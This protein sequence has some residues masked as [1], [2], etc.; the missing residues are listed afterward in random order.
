[1]CAVGYREEEYAMFGQ[2]MKGRG[3][4]MEQCLE[5]F[6][7]A[8]TGEPFDYEGRLVQVTPKPMTPGGPTLLMGGSSKIAVRRAARFGMG[9]ITQG[10]DSSLQELYEETCREA[11]T[12]PGMFVNPSVGD[13]V[14][15]GF[16]ARDPDQA[17]AE[18]GSFLLHDAQMYAAWLG[19]AATATRSAAS[20]VEELRAEQGSYR[21]FTPDEAALHIRTSGLLLTQPLCGGLPPKLAW[22]SLE[23]LVEEVLPEVN[24]P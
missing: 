16:V 22:Q 9:M 11:G 1:V 8:F 19:G 2:D 7:Q 17:W 6:R 14:H 10:G 18:M 3:K 23:L 24:S 5:V 20:T 15:S 4:R 13:S 12:T 21:I